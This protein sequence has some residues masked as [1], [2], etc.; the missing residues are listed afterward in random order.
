MALISE[1][2]LRFIHQHRTEN[3]RTLALQAARYP[4]VDMQTAL[5]QISGWQVAREKVPTW[6]ETEGIL[7]PRHLS[8]EQCSSEQTARYKAEVVQR[9]CSEH[10][11]TS[12]ADLTGGFGIDCAFLAAHFPTATYVERQGELCELAQHNFALLGGSHIRVCHA[13]AVTFLEQMQPV[14]FLFLDPARRDDKGGKTVAISD[15]EPDV[16]ALETLLLQK[17]KRVMVKLSP[18][19]DLSLAL[20]DLSHVAEVHVVSVNNECKELLLLLAQQPLADAAATPIHCVNLT[21][22]STQA[23]AFTR[24]EEQNQPLTCA[25][26]LG[27]YLYEPNASLLKA[28][29]F[30]TLCNIYKVEKLHPNSHLYTSQLLV[31]DFPGRTF[32]IVQSC[33]F[34]KK[35]LK[36]LLSGIK[37]ANLTVRNFPAT[38]AELRRRLKLAD[39][40]STYLFATT[41]ANEDKLLIAGERL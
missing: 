5:T 18:M 27:Q 41:L 28:G 15:C 1:D 24:V 14:D 40:G 12:F 22:H 2:T 32:R 16:K 25:S 35:E 37:Q 9:V 38:V 33:G 20:N 6:A 29:A 31:P 36:Q 19:L 34:S 21:S 30:R 8:M 23:I 4:G 11:Y 26:Q 13:D 10:S 3:V 17:A 7:F 39:G